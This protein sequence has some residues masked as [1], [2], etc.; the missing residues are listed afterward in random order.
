[1]KK[2][3]ILSFLC[4]LLASCED[5]YAVIQTLAI[6]PEALPGRADTVMTDAAGNFRFSRIKTRATGGLNAGWTLP[7]ERR[8]KELCV[9]VTGRARSNY[10]HSNAD[11]VLAASSPTNKLTVWRAVHLRYFNVDE[12]HWFP[13]RDS[14][15]LKATAENEVYSSMN[16]FAFLGDSEKETFD[17]DTLKVII[18]EK[19]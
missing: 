19:L 9:V 13:F 8:N 10:A 14:F 1:M 11:I 5:R 3:V 16:I 4:L 15:L 7:E 12:N 17:M 2:P 6:T 18:K